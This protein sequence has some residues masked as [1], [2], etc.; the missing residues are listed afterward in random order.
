MSNPLTSAALPSYRRLKNFSKMPTTVILGGGI[1]ALS[2]AYYA[3]L[4]SSEKIHILESNAS[5]FQSASGRA[6]GFLAR[7]WFSPL[8]SELGALSFDLHQKL[9]HEHNGPEN[10][11]FSGS[12]SISLS[13]IDGSTIRGEDWLMRD[14]SRA[15]VSSGAVGTADTNPA[16]L[17]SSGMAEVISRP[18]TTA[19][20]DPLR[21]CQFLLKQ[22]IERGVILH[23]PAKA[24][25]I[26]TDDGVLTGA[27]I[28]ESGTEKFIPCQKILIACSVWS[29]GV[30]K[31]LF[32]SASIRIPITSLAGH[33]L[34]L[35][36]P[37]W[38]SE[39]TSGCH[40]IFMT[41]P[42]GWSPELFSRQ[43]GELYLG[44]LNSSTIPVPEFASDVTVQK[45]DI[46][47]MVKTAKILLGDGM[48]IIRAGLCHRPVTSTGRPII[49]KIPSGD[50]GLNDVDGSGG[51]YLASGH[52]PWGITLSLG[53]GKVMAEMMAGE[54][55]SADV[56]KLGF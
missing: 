48:E 14:T 23:Q 35:H 50:I 16:W 10:W 26:R 17:M 49:G 51:V 28:T 29:P 2:T 34:V 30:F 9:A 44:G 33:S 1:I 53:T 3:S 25:R 45:N 27:Y 37:K 6:A 40:A 19:Q 55:T 21:L 52:G 43:G 5:L 11:G 24:T 15:Q 42:D 22:C 39:D 38:K 13:P 41:S 20:V 31:Q 18:D 36:S 12:T 8:V 7:D 47:V 56:E 32:P 46:E 54:R 4:Y